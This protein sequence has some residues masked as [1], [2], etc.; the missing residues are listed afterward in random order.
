M[1]VQLEEPPVF[2]VGVG[3]S[4]TTLLQSILSAH[5]RIAVTPE[6]HFCAIAEQHAGGPITQAPRDFEAVWHG[7]GANKRFAD[8]GVA[9]ERARAILER[10]GALTIRDAFAALLAAYGEAQGKPRVGEKTPG[11]W[12]HARTLLDWFPEA[13]VLVTRRDPRA[14][15]ASKM[16]AP[17]APSYM[18]FHGTALR[19]LTRLHVVAAEARHWTRVYGQA[20]PELLR[21]PRAMMVPYEA[22]VHDPEG[23]VR[24]VCAFLGEAFHPAMLGD[25][26]GQREAYGP[27]T[28]AEWGGWREGHLEASRRPVSDASLEKWRADL[29][30]REVATVEALAGE[31]MERYGYDLTSTPAARRAARRLAGAATGAGTVEIA[32]RGAIGL[33]ARAARGILRAPTPSAR[34]GP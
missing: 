5:P 19:R 33:A 11:H 28:Q 14:V 10:G 1:T 16:K 34:Q 25:R 23:L 3:R 18:R 27:G 20:M 6:T 17:W 31:T 32:A 29:T 4:G 21:D 2:I 26:G 22:L 9:P 8:L 7:Y 30:P 24:E 15:V 13:R 12:R